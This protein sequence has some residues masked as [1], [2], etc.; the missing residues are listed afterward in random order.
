M[1]SSTFFRWVF[2]HGPIRFYFLSVCLY[3]SEKKEL[4]L[5]RRLNSFFGS[6][7]LFSSR[8]HSCAPFSSSFPF[9]FNFIPTSF[10]I[11]LYATA[12]FFRLAMAMLPLPARDSTAAAASSYTSIYRVV[13]Q[14][15]CSF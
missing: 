8:Y 10:P 13:V 11:P 14:C 3:L 9:T 7:C 4:I 2:F 15:L 12:N 1:I 5:F 6:S